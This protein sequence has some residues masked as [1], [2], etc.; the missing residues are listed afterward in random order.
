MVWMCILL[1]IVCPST[2]WNEPKITLKNSPFLNS[3]KKTIVSHLFGIKII[4]FTYWRSCFDKKKGGK[5]YNKIF[6]NARKNI[7]LSGRIFT[8]GT[9]KLRICQYKTLLLILSRV[10]S[11]SCWLLGWVSMKWTLKP[12]VAYIHSSYMR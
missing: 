8:V 1:T 2:W 11:N 3:S 9:K 6:F 10:W 7:F 12:Q 4:F 5:L